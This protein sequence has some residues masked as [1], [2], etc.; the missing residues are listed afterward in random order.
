[1]NSSD[2]D[3]REVVANP[4]IRLVVGHEMRTAIA[5]IGRILRLLSAMHAAP[6]GPDKAVVVNIPA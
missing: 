6:S 3:F 1:M 5:N 4:R 2:L